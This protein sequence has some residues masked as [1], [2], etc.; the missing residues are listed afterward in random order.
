[1]SK[2]SDQDISALVEA[3]R[4]AREKAY[5]PYSRFQV[6]A[7]LLGHSGRI[8]PGCN[9]ENASYGLC[10]CAE[11]TAVVSAVAAG[12]RDYHAIA[13]IADTA[14]AVSPCGSCRQFL[15]EF[16]PGMAVILTNLKGDQVRTTAA[17]LLPGHF[18]PADLKGP[19]V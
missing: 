7:A 11:R 5:A 15:V 9:V 14:G 18:G 4:Q 1:M 3:A 19:P 13:V 2:L 17:E 8:Y 12:E 16:N 10:F 6:G